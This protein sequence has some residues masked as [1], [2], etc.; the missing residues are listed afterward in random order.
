MYQKI[1]N[2]LSVEVDGV[3]L[4]TVKKIEFY[5]RQGDVF[6]EYIPTIVNEHEMFVTIPKADADA[7][8]PNILAYLQFAYT[9][10]NGNDIPSEIIEVDVKKLL[11]E[12]GYNG[13]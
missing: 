5:I 1:K 12:E 9:D 8:R 2:T 3:D 4:T 13:G 11:K 10:I 7:L 6:F